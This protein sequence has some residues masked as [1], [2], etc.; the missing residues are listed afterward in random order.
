MK[1]RGKVDDRN[2][3]NGSTQFSSFDVVYFRM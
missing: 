1:E 3:V 2:R